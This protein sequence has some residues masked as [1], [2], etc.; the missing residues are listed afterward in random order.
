MEKFT[1]ASRTGP[2]LA[3]GL[4]EGFGALQNIVPRLFPGPS[5][6]PTSPRLGKPQG[7]QEKA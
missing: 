5:S 1:T 3:E 2:R 6:S 4:S 7:L